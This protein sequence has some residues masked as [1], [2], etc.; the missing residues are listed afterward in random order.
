VSVLASFMGVW[1]IVEGDVDGATFAFVI[2]M[3]LR[4]SAQIAGEK[5]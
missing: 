1:W 2:S 3:H 5:L 4:Q